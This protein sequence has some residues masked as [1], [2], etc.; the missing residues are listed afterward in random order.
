MAKRAKPNTEEGEVGKPIGALMAAPGLIQEQPGGGVD[1]DAGVP[2]D[3]TPGAVSAPPPVGAVPSDYIPQVD[4]AATSPL[5]KVSEHGVTA[6]GGPDVAALVETVA[7]TA[8]GALIAPLSDSDPESRLAGFAVKVI[9]PKR[10]RR[11]IGRAFGS[12]PVLIPMEDLSRDEV[13]ALNADPSLTVEVVPT[14]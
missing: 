7:A 3:E 2:A 10:G 5:P 8:T 4:G 12:D 6:A 11:R 9:G 14:D 1:G 13:E